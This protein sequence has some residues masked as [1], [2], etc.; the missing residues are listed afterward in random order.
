MNYLIGTIIMIK[1]EYSAALCFPGSGSSPTTHPFQVFDV[2]NFCLCEL[3]P[4]PSEYDFNQSHSGVQGNE[5]LRKITPVALPN[6]FPF[7]LRIPHL[8]IRLFEL[9]H[10]SSMPCRGFGLTLPKTVSYS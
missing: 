8:L 10:L 9:R 2:P 1:Y 3:S 4:F 5:L 7:H 6:R